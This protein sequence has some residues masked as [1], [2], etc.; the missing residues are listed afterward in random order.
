MPKKVFFGCFKGFMSCAI[1]FHQIFTTEISCNCIIVADNNAKKKK[2]KTYEKTIQS[3]MFL[4]KSFFEK[5][6]AKSGN[7]MPNRVKKSLIKSIA[8]LAFLKGMM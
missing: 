2:R 1:S 7:K 8:N 6:K 4:R 3:T 5:K